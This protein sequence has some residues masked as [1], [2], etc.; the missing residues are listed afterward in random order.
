MRPNTIKQLWRDDKPALGAWLGSASTIVAEQL[1]HA[2]FD[3]L[4]VD[5]EHSPIDTLTMVQMMQAISTTDTIP[6][7]RVQWN[8]AVEIKRALDGGAYGVVIPWVNSK[9]EA[10]Q[11][12]AACRYPPMG[13][14]GHGP[15]RGVLYGGPDYR[16]HA[17]EEI[18]C[19]VQIETIGAVEHIDEI[20]SVSGLDATLIGP[21][22]LAMSMNIPVVPDNPHPDHIA[23]C[24]EVLAGCR[25]NGVVPGIYTAGEDE[26]ARRVAEG[27]RFISIGTDGGYLT[28]GA[29]RG[30]EKVRAVTPGG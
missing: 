3:W 19:I 13:S 14:R 10:E 11:A 20:L 26:S 5:G 29:R 8:D 12:V 17:N 7:A 28:Q 1:A 27:W 21:A 25:R 9:A 2:G 4:L 23:A 22:D 6:I 30:L 18:A 24:A 16:L 15:Y